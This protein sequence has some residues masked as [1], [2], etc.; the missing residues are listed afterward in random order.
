MNFIQHESKSFNFFF[1]NNNREYINLTLSDYKTYV[2][3]KS[4]N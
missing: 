1:K 2:L 3:I 4:S